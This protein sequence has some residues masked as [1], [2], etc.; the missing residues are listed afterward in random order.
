MTAQLEK[1]REESSK[2]D[3]LISQL[4]QQNHRL[5]EQ[6]RQMCQRESSER[7]TKR[8]PTLQTNV[9]VVVAIQNAMGNNYD[10]TLPFLH[11]VNQTVT[12]NVINEL[13][14]N[15]GGQLSDQD[16]T[17][18][19]ATYFTNQKKDVQRE[20]NGTKGRHR[21]INRSNRRK[22]KKLDERTLAVNDPR[23]NLTP[24]ERQLGQQVVNLGMAGVSSDEDDDNGS[25]PS[26]LKRPEKVWKVKEFSWRS[27]KMG[28][29]VAKLDTGFVEDIASPATKRARRPFIRDSTCVVSDR[30]PPKN[31]EAWMLNLG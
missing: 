24:E 31:V 22:R 28:A 12:D 3:Q 1:C 26:D 19:C 4:T 20:I 2:K 13:N 21:G 5:E 27:S 10:Y 14:K 16:I 11:T 6:I 9:K 29:I 8:D 18:A 30:R 15:G 23:V 25:D 17:S 7:K